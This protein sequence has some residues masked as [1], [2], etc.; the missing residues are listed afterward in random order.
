M[1][2]A[3]LDFLAPS[4]DELRVI[5]LERI[6][7]KKIHQLTDE[8]VRKLAPSSLWGGMVATD[9]ASA[10]YDFQDIPL[11]A[12]IGPAG[13]GDRV[14][15]VTVPPRSETRP[16]SELIDPPRDSE[17]AIPELRRRFRNVIDAILSDYDDEDFVAVPGEG[18]E[19]TEAPAGSPEKIAVLRLRA[20]RGFPL[21]HDDDRRDYRDLCG[22][23]PPRADQ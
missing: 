19:P 16:T 6:R 21:W 18:F 5:A 23:I 14:P 22:A 9:I 7:V 8:S 17:D 3:A 4:M 1:A 12:G 15:C 11:D 2:E 13:G 10:E 20:E